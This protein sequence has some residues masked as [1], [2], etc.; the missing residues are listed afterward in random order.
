M[1]VDTKKKKVD[2][3]RPRWPSSLE[4]LS[5]SNENSNSS[6]HS[7]EDPGSNPAQDTNKYGHALKIHYKLGNQIMFSTNLDLK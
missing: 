6:R 1:R 7:L 2:T 3:N 4:R 5:N